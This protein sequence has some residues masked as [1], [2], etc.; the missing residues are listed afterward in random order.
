MS[1]L[2]LILL[3]FRSLNNTLPAHEFE[4]DGGADAHGFAVDEA[5]VRMDSE[6]HLYVDDVIPRQ[7]VSTMHQAGAAV[8]R[9]ASHDHVEG[10]ALNIYGQ[11]PQ[12]HAADVA[13]IFPRL[14]HAIIRGSC[15]NV[16]VLSL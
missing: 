1:A 5:E 16:V 4:H 3:S 14:A 9:P 6:L 10:V 12:R 2:S 7:D 13:L 15:L 11:N 8:H